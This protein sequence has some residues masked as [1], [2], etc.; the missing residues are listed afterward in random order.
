ELPRVLAPL[1]SSRG[2]SGRGSAEGARRARDEL[3]RHVPSRGASRLRA[4]G[5]AGAVMMRLACVLGLVAVTIAIL[6]TLDTNGH[7]AIAFSFVGAPALGL[8]L[9]IYGASRWRASSRGVSAAR[10]GTPRERAHDHAN[11]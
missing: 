2:T 8:A 6:L 9:A 3:H 10:F 1:S 11:L 7:T 5:R 4:D